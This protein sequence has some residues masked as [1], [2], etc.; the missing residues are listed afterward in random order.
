MLREDH[1]P[2]KESERALTLFLHASLRDNAMSLKLIFAVSLIAVFVAWYMF[3]VIPSL[4]PPVILLVT[5]I[6]LLCSP[7]IIIGHGFTVVPS[8]LAL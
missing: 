6:A 1:C 8:L 2:S 7:G 5:F 3:S 4:T